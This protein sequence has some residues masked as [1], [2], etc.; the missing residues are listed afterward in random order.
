MVLP[1]IH[2]R[3]A[4]LLAGGI[5]VVAAVLWAL[6]PSKGRGRA[7]HRT[8]PDLQESRGAAPGAAPDA[9][10]V[11]SGFP[12]LI[13]G[14]VA[15][16]EEALRNGETAQAQAAAATLRRL[17]RLDEEA[18]RMAE[19]LLLD[20]QTGRELRMA[21][22]LVLGTLPGGAADPALLE[23]LGRFASDAAFV[24]CGL[25]ALGATREPPE[26]DEIFGLGDRPWGASGPGGLGIT[27]RR[28]IGDPHLRQ[29]LA[30]YLEDE[31]G[32]VRQAAAV[33][34]RHTV[35]VREVRH[36]FLAALATENRDEVA[37]ELGESLAS[38]AGGAK[39]PEGRAEVVARLLARAADKGLDGYRFRIEDDF[40][41]VALD[42]GQRT[43]LREYARPARPFGVR[44][45]A[46]EVLAGSAV[47]S[48]GR[49]VCETRELLEETLAGD[50]ESAIRDLSARLLGR[51]PYDRRTVERLAAVTR[52]DAAWNVRYT[53][54]GAL[55]SFS[56]RPE[57]LLALRAA[58]ADPDTRV[59]ER[60]RE[61]VKRLE[62]RSR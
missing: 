30:L 49:A 25:L 15:A 62:A 45:F 33:V 53:A 12:P 37:L 2:R 4:L 48:G 35:S 50:P 8:P 16:L 1:R 14:P 13:R 28:F 32:E 57:A 55:G 17:L 23:A 46:L 29:T 10:Q 56:P 18:R 19:S 22:A 41:R 60:A 5:L 31:R 42:G 21:L 43:L 7:P 58:V 39:D 20:E 27:V 44:G 52:R 47:R 3:W 59:A 40:R 6:A 38:W 34:L 9:G 26:D 54:L 51:L 36:A 11:A 61:L 24:R